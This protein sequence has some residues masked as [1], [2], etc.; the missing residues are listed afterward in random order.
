MNRLFLFFSRNRVFFTFLILEYFS[1]WLVINRNSYQ[2]ASFFQF[3]IEW[4]GKIDEFKFEILKTL[5]LKS[6]NEELMS[7]NARLKESLQNLKP[8]F[9]VRTD[10][11]P[12]ILNRYYFIPAQVINQTTELMNNYLTLD[13][14]R[15]DGISIGM[16]VLSSSGVVGKVISASSNFSLA[17]SILNPN[18]FIASQLTRTGIQGSS[19]WDGENIFRSKLLFIPMNLDVRVGD[20]IVSSGYNSVF[21]PGIPIGIVSRV[22]TEEGEA[23]LNITINLFHDFKRNRPVYGVG[24]R[25]SPEKDTLE[26][27]I[28]GIP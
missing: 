21:P 23:Y 27:L 6:E 4:G 20:S 19:K 24:D 2:Q 10:L 18:F 26:I 9:G 28:P 14:G 13:K 7:E 25:L 17:Q 3:S 22:R 15:K 16:G 1:F 11:P 12:E 5:S 8:K